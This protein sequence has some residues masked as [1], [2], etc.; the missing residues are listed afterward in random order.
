MLVVEHLVGNYIHIYIKDEDIMSGGTWS[1]FNTFKGIMHSRLI[2]RD[3]LVKMYEPVINSQ[4]LVFYY[5]VDKTNA[6]TIYELYDLTCH[7]YLIAN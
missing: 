1:G 2:S 6:A 7:T 5:S 3:K 4:G